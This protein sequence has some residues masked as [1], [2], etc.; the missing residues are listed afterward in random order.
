MT[1]PGSPLHDNPRFSSHTN[2]C[3]GSGLND[4]LEQP[5]LGRLP[6]GRVRPGC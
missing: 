2:A 4:E 3:A 6:P 1:L 5:A